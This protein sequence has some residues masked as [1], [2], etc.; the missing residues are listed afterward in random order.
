MFNQSQKHPVAEAGALPARR[1]THRPRGR[2]GS[3]GCACSRP[4]WGSGWSSGAG[5]LR[6]MWSRSYQ[7]PRCS[8]TSHPGGNRKG[9]THGAISFPPFSGFNISSP[10]SFP[11]NNWVG[12]SCS[13]PSEALLAPWASQGHSKQP[14]PVQGEVVATPA[15]TRALLPA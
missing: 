13:P 5:Q 11:K 7:S 10:H 1:G 3:A 14:F 2:A 15:G 12:S 9:L 4:G 6:S 8:P